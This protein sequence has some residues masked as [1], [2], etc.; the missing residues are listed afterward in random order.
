M[1]KDPDDRSEY[2]RVVVIGEFHKC[3]VCGELVPLGT[4]GCWLRTY[5][6]LVIV[7]HVE[8]DEDKP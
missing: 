3:H 1:T 7:W 2:E 8:C 4:W 5:D 6:G